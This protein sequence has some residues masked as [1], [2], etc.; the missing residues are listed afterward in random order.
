MARIIKDL[1]KGEKGKWG[2]LTLKGEDQKVIK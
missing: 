1:E 2:L